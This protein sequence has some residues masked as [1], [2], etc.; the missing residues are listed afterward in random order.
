MSRWNRATR[1]LAILVAAWPSFARGAE[2]PAPPSPEQVEAARVP[3]REARELQRQGRTSE[4]AARMLDAYHV[5]S[6]PV[7][8]LEAGRLLIDVG[9]LVEAREILRGVTVLPVSPR[10]T[11]AGR[12]ARR[13]SA[14]LATELDTRIPKISLSQ[15]PAGLEVLLDGQPFAADSSAWQGVDPG[16]HT[17]VVRAQDHV[18][19]TIAVTLAAGEVRTIDLR[20]AAAACRSAP[21][22]P[23]PPPSAEVAGGAPDAGPIAPPTEDDRRGATWRWGGAA[24]AGVGLVTAG[25]GTYLLVAA[26]SDYDSVASQ[27]T[28]R[29]CSPDAYDVRHDAHVRANAATV[30]MGL[31]VAAVIGGAVMW[32]A[33]DS[34]RPDAPPRV[35]VGPAG[36]S[37]S[38]PLR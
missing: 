15:R 25:V 21:T 37:L 29:G 3:F 19:T 27:C 38:V 10:E 8:G 22:P 13:E 32:F 4:A 35:G 24:L 34:G 17:I 30:V 14:A 36:V 20:D 1:A 16:G 12:D 28:P 7:I 23:P 33:L 2:P 5:A 11:D 9:R 18:C 6:T 26:K 31:G